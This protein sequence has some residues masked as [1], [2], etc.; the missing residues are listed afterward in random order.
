MVRQ[1]CKAWRC[2]EPASRL[3]KRTQ[4]NRETKMK[5]LGGE[6]ERE[7]MQAHKLGI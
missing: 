2:C 6:N 1:G 5:R 3:W 4:G 7:G